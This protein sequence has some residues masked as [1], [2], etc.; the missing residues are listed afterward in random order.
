LINYVLYCSEKISFNSRGA[1]YDYIQ[2][3]KTYFA[4]SYYIYEC[5][6][7]HKWHLSHLSKKRLKMSNDSRHK[8]IDKQR[9]NNL[10]NKFN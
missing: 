5:K 3:N 8:S 9:F 1:A 10:K 6:E 4:K 7:C 2:D